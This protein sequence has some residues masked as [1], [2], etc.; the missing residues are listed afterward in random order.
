[1]TGGSQVGIFF[2][3]SPVSTN[4]PRPTGAVKPQDENIEQ[5]SQEVGTESS[6]SSPNQFLWGRL[7]F[8]ILLLAV[9][10]AG[11]V[12]TAHDDK[13]ADWSKLFVHSFE[14]LLG[15]LVGLLTGEASKK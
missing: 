10:F 5:M 3:S 14:L 15:A 12:Y 9:V 7:L 8:A 6:P 13:L 4:L 11:G 2:R 1:M